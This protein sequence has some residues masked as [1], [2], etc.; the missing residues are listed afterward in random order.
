MGR[1]RWCSSELV[2]A[3]VVGLWKNIRR[4]WREVSKSFQI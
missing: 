1:M 3:N 2:G 4:G